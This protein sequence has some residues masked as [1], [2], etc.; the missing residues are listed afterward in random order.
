[1]DLQELQ[2]QIPSFDVTFTHL[3]HASQA[4]VPTGPS[5]SD[6]NAGSVSNV[7]AL[8]R[9]RSGNHHHIPTVQQLSTHAEL[10]ENNILHGSSNHQEAPSSNTLQT[11]TPSTSIS[12]TAHTQVA[13]TQIATET[14]R[15][16]STDSFNTRNPSKSTRMHKTG[17]S[18]PAKLGFYSPRSKSILKEAKLKYRIYIATNTAFPTTAQ[19]IENAAIK[20]NS[21]CDE[22]AADIETDRGSL[23]PIDTG[24]LQVVRFCM[25]I[26][27][28]LY[29]IYGFLDL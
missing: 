28:L 3:N 14:R 27:I 20:Y 25:H 11:H 19:A 9:S 13:N 26:C 6:L 29:S 8:H 4:Q 16:S 2:K 24:R 18:S 22:Y 15:S 12:S 5:S 21:T 7:L 10:L 17:Q 1:M 23:P